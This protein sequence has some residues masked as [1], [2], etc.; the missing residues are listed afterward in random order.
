MTAE[1]VF[2]AA[3]MVLVAAGVILAFTFMGSPGHARAVAIDQRRVE[4][5]ARIAGIVDERASETG[6][7]PKT[8]PSDIDA[9]DPQ[10]GKPYGYRRIDA[11]RYE[12]C[13]TFLLAG[14]ADG[15][16]YNYYARSR[17]WKHRA[18]HACFTL[19]SWLRTTP[20]GSRV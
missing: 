10:T 18:G 9:T 6:A 20:H 7:V 15:A 19:R 11:E 14:D 16:R 5:L 12:L 4:A 13:A 2:G 3:A 1:R 8:L 17:R